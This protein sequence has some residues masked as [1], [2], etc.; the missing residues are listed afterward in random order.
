MGL[1][2]ASGVSANTSRLFMLHF[3]RKG[4]IFVLIYGVTVCAERLHPAQR[5]SVYVGHINPQQT[6]QLV[7]A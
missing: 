7:S 1:S 2:I 5:A 6:I 3:Y 4:S